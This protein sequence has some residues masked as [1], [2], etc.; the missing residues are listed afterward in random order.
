M[1]AA[2]HVLFFKIESI[3][4]MEPRILERFQLD[5]NSAEIVRTWAF[6]QGFY[7]LFLAFGLFYALFQINFRKKES[8]ILLASFILITIF[9]AG[10]VLLASAPQKWSASL[11]QSMPA[12]IGL[13]FLQL[14]SKKK[15]SRE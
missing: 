8:A 4:F 13:I 14:Y 10:G 15:L 1:T 5:Q 2:I 9:C 6:N 11:M 7:N 3:D 12:L